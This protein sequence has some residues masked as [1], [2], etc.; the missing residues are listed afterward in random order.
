MCVC[1]LSHS[2]LTLYHSLSHGCVLPRAFPQKSCT[3]STWPAALC[4]VK[5]CAIK[6]FLNFNSCLPT[7]AYLDTCNNISYMC[8]TNATKSGQLSYHRNT[9]TSQLS[10]NYFMPPFFT[11][12]YIF[13][14]VVKFLFTTYEASRKSQCQLIIFRGL[15]KY[16]KIF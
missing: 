8:R 1:V 6:L 7:F 3:F 12:F 11:S 2:S 4:L 10:A 5:S 14:V 16:N 13:S 9:E 15:A